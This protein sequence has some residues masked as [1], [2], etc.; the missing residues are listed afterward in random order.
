MVF[1][2]VVVSAGGTREPWDEVRFLGNRSSGRQGCEVARAAL[3]TGAEVTLVCANVFEALIPPGAKVVEAPT[4]ADML[5]EM[6]RAAKTADLIVMCAAVAD[7]RPIPVA[8]KITRH[9]DT[10][11]VMEL[12]RTPDV[13]LHLIQE[14]QPHQ[15]I[16]GF[17]ALTGSDREVWEH[18][19]E[20]ARDKGADLLCINKVG[21]GMGFGAD[22]NTLIFFDA[23][24]KELRRASGTKSQVSRVLLDVAEEI[25]QNH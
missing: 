18:G 21:D 12:E 9:S 19:R 6:D 10:L 3:E 14:K 22:T 2:S 1:R 15:T 16:V 23:T 7:F 24:G 25:S 11:P 20:K 4:A 5:R 17:G 13:L 8:G